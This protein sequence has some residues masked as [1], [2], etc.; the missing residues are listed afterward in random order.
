MVL[1]RIQSNN[2]PPLDPEVESVFVEEEEV[3]EEEVL[4]P[5]YL[6]HIWVT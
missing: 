4:L 5:T 1:T 6:Y 3:V 2:P